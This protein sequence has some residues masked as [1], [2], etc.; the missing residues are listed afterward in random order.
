MDGIPFFRRSGCFGQWMDGYTFRMFGYGKMESPKVTT[1]TAMLF[2]SPAV[3][4]LLSSLHNSNVGGSS[5]HMDYK[6]HMARRVR[7]SK[8]ST[9]CTK[10]DKTLL[11]GER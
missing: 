10:R 6:W 2:L 3:V 1:T 11:E 8:S 7:V 5:S 4:P 9:Q